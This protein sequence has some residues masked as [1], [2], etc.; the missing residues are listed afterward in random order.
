[1]NEQSLN[2]EY[3]IGETAYKGDAEA[4]GEILRSYAQFHLNWKSFLNVALDESGLSYDRF[5][6]SCGIEKDTLK[7]WC[8]SGG[9]PRSRDAYIRI[10]FGLGM[11]EVELNQMLLCCGGYHEL[12]A[13]DLFDA[14]CI[15]TLQKAGSYWDALS[16]YQ[17]CSEAETGEK[18]G[19]EAFRVPGGEQKLYGERHFLGFIQERQELFDLQ[20]SRLS[21][22]VREFL[23]MRQWEL[24]IIEGRS[25]SLH[26][27]A[28][29]IGL[30]PH[31][32]KMLSRLY[33]QEEVPRR[34]KLI[35]LGLQLDM[36]P[37]SLDI[38]LELAHMK[39]LT[40]RNRLDCILVYAL[41]KIDILH[42]DLSFSNV[43]QFL[44][45]CRNPE[46]KKFCAGRIQD[47]L[48]NSYDSNA[49]EISKVVECIHHLLEEVNAEE[50]G[51][52]MELL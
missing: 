48:E 12:Q 24:A 22:Y 50:A 41:Q 47:Y 18:R 49:E 26:T 25:F 45:I 21:Q 17:R 9:L 27:W 6:E 44:Q 11:S 2:A 32:E 10:A 37:D 52:L 30:P 35:A 3:M 5:A 19:E 15:F 33:Q 40:S 28:E 29:A 1:M 20:R 31:F 13:N 8:V 23:H 51:Q 38:M 34:E 43:Q 46:L 42:P 7:K 4:L 36:R 39:G 14:A 16:L